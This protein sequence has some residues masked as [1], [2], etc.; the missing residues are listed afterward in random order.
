VDEWHSCR[1]FWVPAV[2]NEDLGQL[3]EHKHE[4]AAVVQ[5]SVEFIA[6]TMRHG[7]SMN[8]MCC[9][10]TVVCLSCLLLQHLLLTDVSTEKGIQV[11]P[12]LAYSYDTW[13][14]VRDNLGIRY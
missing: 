2:K 8:E 9:C 5:N 11:P 1:Q 10:G 13:G 4:T 14:C 12:C 6:C 7:V 3:D